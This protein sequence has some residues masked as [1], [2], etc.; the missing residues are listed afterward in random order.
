MKAMVVTKFGA[1]MEIQEVAR[2]KFGDTDV[3]IRVKACGLCGTDLKIFDGKVPTVKLPSIMGHEVSGIVEEVGKGV[4]GLRPGD[5]GVVHIYITCG[6]CFYCRNARENECQ[7]M[8]GRIGFEL[9]GG[10]GEYLRV[11][12]RNFY[13]VSPKVPLEEVA[14]LSGSISTPI[15]AVR[16]QGR[17]RMGETAVVIGIGGLGIHS[18]QLAVALGA[19]V[20]AVDIDDKKL[21]VAKSFGADVLINSA[22]VD[23]PAAVRELTGGLGADMASEII[24]GPKIPEV[25]DQAIQCLR[26]GGRLVILGYDYGQRLAIDPQKI[27]YDELEIIGSRSS[28]RQDLIDVISLVERGKVKPLVAETVP[29]AEANDA[30]RRLRHSEAVGRMVLML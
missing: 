3:L 22:K 21:D 26:L 6:S 8:E 2:P 17:L 7:T 4:K 19:R 16:T 9:P 11:P 1:P 13:K 15:H 25:L 18:L 24:G 29:L 5:H 28:T 20:I 14:I 30:F 12:E 10:F 23:W 27:V